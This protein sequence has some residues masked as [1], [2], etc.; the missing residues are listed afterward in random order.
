MNCKMFS[1]KVLGI[2]DIN[3]MFLNIVN[4][5]MLMSRAMSYRQLIK[6]SY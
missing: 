2:S 6:V 5:H 4:V 3:A 1:V